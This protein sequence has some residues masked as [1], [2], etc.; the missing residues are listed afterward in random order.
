MGRNAKYKDLSGER[1]GM[2]LV[3]SRTKEIGKFGEVA[4]YVC[5]CQCQDKTI[6]TAK[7]TSLR[8]GAKDNCGCL[9]KQKQRI[10]KKKYNRYDLSGEYGMGYTIKGDVFYFDLKDFYKIVDFCWNIHDGYVEARCIDGSNT[11]AKMHRIVM[12]ATETNQIVDHKNRRKNDNRKSNLRVVNVR[13]N[14]FNG[15][16]RKNNTSGFRGITWRN[17]N[18]KWRVRIGKDYAEKTIGHYDTLEDAISAR[19]NAEQEYYGEYAR[20]DYK[21]VK[22]DIS[23]SSSPQPIYEHESPRFGCNQ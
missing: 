19:R 13:E 14:N 7:S 21:E 2:L 6:V 18:K 5:E 23:K 11:T 3:I 4:E 12:N 1:F 10:A 17:D 16:E 8:S 22:I 9:T 15:G 20:Q